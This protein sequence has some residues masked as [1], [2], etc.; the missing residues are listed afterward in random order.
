VYFGGLGFGFGYLG[1]AIVDLLAIRSALPITRVLRPLNQNDELSRRGGQGLF[2]QKLISCYDLLPQ[3]VIGGVEV[4]TSGNAD[5]LNHGLRRLLAFES[6]SG[7][8]NGR[9]VCLDIGDVVRDVFTTS[10]DSGE[11]EKAAV[12]ERSSGS[13]SV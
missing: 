9:S 3:N 5:R 1:L 10:D 13:C 12:D 2:G 7:G 4:W 6:G 11:P 8:L